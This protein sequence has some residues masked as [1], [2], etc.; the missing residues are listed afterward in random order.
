M[1]IMWNG[2]SQNTCICKV[3]LCNNITI[4]NSVHKS[5]VSCIPTATNKK[6]I[7]I[8]QAGEKIKLIFHCL[9]II[10]HGQSLSHEKMIKA[11]KC[12][13]KDCRGVSGRCLEIRKLCY[14]LGFLIYIFVYFLKFAAWNHFILTS[15]HITFIIHFSFILIQ[16]FVLF[17]E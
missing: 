14:F 3:G 17:F 13:T 7:L 8:N 5:H 4:R 6:E 10:R 16:Y 2:I 9:Y 15:F 11:T 1:G 12:R